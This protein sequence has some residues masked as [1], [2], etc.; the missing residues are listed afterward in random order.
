MNAFI[1]PVVYEHLPSVS[2]Q[3]SRAAARKP[4][5]AAAIP[6]GFYCHVVAFPFPVFMST[7]STFRPSPHRCVV[8]GYVHV[9]RN[10]KKANALSAV[11]RNAALNA[12]IIYVTTPGCHCVCRPANASLHIYCSNTNL[13]AISCWLNSHKVYYSTLI[14]CNCS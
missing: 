9:V 6:V 4:R 11:K 14:L 8:T 13:P 3:E 2:Q 10:A 7:M 1:S 12:V 5:D